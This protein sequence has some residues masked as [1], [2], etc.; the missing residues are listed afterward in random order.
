MKDLKTS[1]AFSRVKRSVLLL[2]S[3]VLLI[4][5]VGC[6]DRT[7]GIDDMTREEILAYLDDK[8]PDPSPAAA[9]ATP[10]LRPL[11]PIGEADAALSRSAPAAAETPSP[12]PSPTP[13]P[14]PSPTPAPTPKPTPAPTPKPTPTPT[15]QP[16]PAPTVAPTRTNDESTITV[17]ITKTG[18]KYHRSGCSYLSK[19]KIAISL[20]DAK[21]AGYSPCS[22]CW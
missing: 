16:T 5:G 20:S 17:Y 2:L 19:S 22:R 10:V 21:A 15:P 8:Y 7:R 14:A 18:T 12:T 6:G 3:L 13:R 1:A 9:D 11:E 4:S